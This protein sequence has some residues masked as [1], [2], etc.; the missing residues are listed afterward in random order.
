M[1]RSGGKIILF[2]YSSYT[3][4]RTRSLIDVVKSLATTPLSMF[5][6]V[7]LINESKGVMGMNL[8]KMF[9]ESDRLAPWMKQLFQLWAIGK[10]R[11]QIHAAVPFSRAAEAHRMLHD[12]QNL[13]KVLLIPD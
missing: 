8:G 2:G 1:L 5:N 4:G 7:K 6:P 3:P 13:G 10:L 11:V 12:R 9:N